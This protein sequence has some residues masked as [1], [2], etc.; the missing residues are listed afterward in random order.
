MLAGLEQWIIDH[1]V[2]P[3]GGFDD[4]QC[5][6]CIRNRERVYTVKNNYLK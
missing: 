4:V 1:G 3:T 2:L 5:Q 6:G